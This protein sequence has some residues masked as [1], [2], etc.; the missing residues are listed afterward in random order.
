MQKV[1]GVQ[2]CEYFDLKEQ[3]NTF[4]HRYG[5]NGKGIG[6]VNGRV[7][8]GNWNGNGNKGGVNGNG[9]GN[10]NGGGKNCNGNGN[11][12]GVNG[13]SNGNGNNESKNGNG[14][15]NGNHWS[16]LLVYTEPCMLELYKTSRLLPVFFNRSTGDKICMYDFIRDEV[17]NY[18]MN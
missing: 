17:R 13:S 15:G 2:L 6:N 10:G 3:T 14:N 8:N 12:S 5:I 16:T 9:N 7:K 11:K 1:L 18:S 4:C